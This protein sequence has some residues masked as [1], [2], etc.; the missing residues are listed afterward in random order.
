MKSQQIVF[1]VWKP[2]KNRYTKIPEPH[3]GGIEDIFQKMLKKLQRLSEFWLDKRANI[4]EDIRTELGFYLS[5]YPSNRKFLVPSRRGTA[6]IPEFIGILYS[7]KMLNRA[8]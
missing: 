7:H 1:W 3:I 2:K 8:G 5:L 6:K 4:F